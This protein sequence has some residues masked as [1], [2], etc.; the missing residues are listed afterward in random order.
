MAVSVKIS[1]V[2]RGAKKT[3][4]KLQE[5]E[6]LTKPLKQSAI[7]MEKSIGT[8]FRRA[9][10]K[11]LSPATLKIHPHR[12][13]GKPLNDTG[14]LKRSV[15]SKAVKHIG[16]KKLTYGTNLKYAPI[17]NFGGRGGWG[18]YI[19]KREFLYFDDKDE[20]AIRRIFEDYIRELA[21]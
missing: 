21:K 18:R 8:R 15:T 17:H 19:P 14:N 13:G 2:D 4:K 16:N 7:Y 11:P 12:R 9:P 10:W 3:L 5:T 6:N 20:I 1:V